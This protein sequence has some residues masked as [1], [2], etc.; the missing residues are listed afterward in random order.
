MAAGPSPASSPGPPVSMASSPPMPLI[1]RVR[2]SGTISRMSSRIACR[3]GTYG[4]I[5][6]SVRRCRSVFSAVLVFMH[7][8]MMGNLRFDDLIGPPQRLAGGL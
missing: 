2:M 6:N 1:T 4:Q 3:Q 8:V 5:C 7:A